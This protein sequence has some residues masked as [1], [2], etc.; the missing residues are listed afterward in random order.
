[1]HCLY[2][3]STINTGVDGKD[4]LSIVLSTLRYKQNSK[5]A[6]CVEFKSDDTFLCVCIGQQFV[7]FPRLYRTSDSAQKYR[8]KVSS[9][10]LKASS[11]RFGEEKKSLSYRLNVY[12]GWV[13]KKRSKTYPKKADKEWPENRALVGLVRCTGLTRAL[14]VWL[15]LL[16]KASLR[17]CT[18]D[19]WCTEMHTT[20]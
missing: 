15:L 12:L 18:S 17:V 16:L 10:Q 3:K 5:R 9:F 6:L 7:L 1:M 2:W 4:W 8:Q 14:A 13:E 11:S 20:A 19:Q